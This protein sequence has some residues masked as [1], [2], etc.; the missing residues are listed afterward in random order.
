MLFKLIIVDDEALICEGLSKFDYESLGIQLVG[1]YENGLT[2]YQYVMENLVDIIVTDIRMPLMNGIELIECV[3]EKFPSI[4]TIVL[5]GYEDF[6]YVKKCLQNG[7]T[8]YL[9]KPLDSEEYINLFKKIV[10]SLD[11]EKK[12]RLEKATLLQKSYQSVS[13]LR[14]YF[15]RQL[16]SHTLPSNDIEESCL[17]CEL[18][19]ESTYYS[20]CYFKF[21]SH[22][23]KKVEYSKKDWD[24]ILFMLNNII[25]ELWD[26]KEYGY[27]YIDSDNGDCF[28]VILDK[29]IMNN[30]FSQEVQQVLLDNLKYI[31]SK[32]YHFRGLFK[33]TISIA[34]GGIVRNI[35]NINLSAEWAQAML[36]PCLNSNETFLFDFKELD[37]DVNNY[38]ENDNVIETFQYT[39]KAESGKRLIN[40]AKKFIQQNY[41]KAITLSDVANYLQISPSYLSFLY[42]EVTGENYIHFLTLCRM[43]Q[44]KF[45]LQDVKYKVYEISSMVGYETPRYFS[46]LFKKFIGKSPLEYRN[47]FID[48]V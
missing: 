4:K 1:C 20:V 38:T 41:T 15:F 36:K 27:H 25:T 3:K 26:D 42:K 48:V 24:L 10:A 29:N 33:K 19:L 9:L 6:G 12:V 17:T 16:I 13:L 45:L 28:L 37:I 34:I 7:I 39:V 40:E 22:N 8:D 18:L 32:L 21:D 2:A 23:N 5:T 47:S 31:R 35:Q 30:I 43:E 11:I 44:A 46:E 14:K